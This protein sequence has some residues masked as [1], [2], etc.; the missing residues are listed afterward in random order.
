L[1]TVPL[2]RRFVEWNDRDTS[3]P[4]LRAGFYGDDRTL[5]WDA[6]LKR[7]RVVL[8]A[9]AGSGKTEE[10]QARAGKLSENCKFAFYARIQDVGRRG[11][12]LS[13]LPK[14]QTRFDG[15]K[16]SADPGYFLIDS[17]D[18]AKLDNLS[19][20]ECLGQIAAGI[21]GAEGR[22]HVVLSGRHTDLGIPPRLVT[23]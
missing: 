4:D 7:R 8:L 9:E 3:D 15:W 22:A 23:P 17:I 21:E 18:E 14:D 16:A 11:I 20:R 10:L 1:T 5:N 19:L 12:R 6:L 2:D 13:L